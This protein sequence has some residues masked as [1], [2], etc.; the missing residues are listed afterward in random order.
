MTPIGAYS[1]ISPDFFTTMQRNVWGM[2]VGGFLLSCVITAVIDQTY[3]DFGNEICSS[4]PAAEEIIELCTSAVK[5]QA[6]SGYISLLLLMWII[7]YAIIVAIPS[8]K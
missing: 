5:K 8:K 7:S 1:K 2:V 6:A 4:L 3:R